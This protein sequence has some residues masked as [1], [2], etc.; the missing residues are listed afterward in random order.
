MHQ[1][2]ALHSVPNEAEKYLTDVVTVGDVSDNHSTAVTNKAK[3][4][5]DQ[6]K[7]EYRKLMKEKWNKKQMHGKFKSYLDKEY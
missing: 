7:R 5:K 3:K 2:K 4:W 1:H 6:C